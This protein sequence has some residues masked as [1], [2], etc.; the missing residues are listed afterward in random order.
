ML[1]LFVVVVWIAVWISALV[2]VWFGLGGLL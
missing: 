2:I 1:V